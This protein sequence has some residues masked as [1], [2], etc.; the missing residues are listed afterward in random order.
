MKDINMF[1]AFDIETTG[2]S[3]KYNQIIEIAALKYKNG[4]QVDSFHSL[5]NPDIPIPWR[6]TQITGIT[7][8]MIKDA[9]AIQVVLPKFIGFIEDYPLVAHNSNFDMGFI[10][11][12]ASLLNITVNNRVI[13]TLHISRKAFPSLQNHKLNTLCQHLDIA[14]KEH[15]RAMADSAAAAEIFLKCMKAAN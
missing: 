8:N 5:I 3:P 2:L 6:I 1:V 9:P 12:K 13:D 15:H 7:T 4:Q 10:K 11:N 14:L